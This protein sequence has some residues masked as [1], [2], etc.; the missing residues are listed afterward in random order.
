MLTSQ[1]GNGRAPTTTLAD[2]VVMQSQMSANSARSSELPLNGSRHY[3]TNVGCAEEHVCTPVYVPEHA[4]RVRG[5]IIWVE[6][7]GPVSM[8]QL[9]NV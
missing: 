6:A 4:V 8:R 5:T 3:H 1:R 9:E 2:G 7:V